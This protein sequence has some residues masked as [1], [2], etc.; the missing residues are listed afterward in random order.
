MSAVGGNLPMAAAQLNWFAAPRHHGVEKALRAAAGEVVVTK[1]LAPPTVDVV[2]ELQ[3]AGKRLTC[4]AA[5]R[6]RI[7]LEQHPHLR[8]QQLAGTE[9]RACLR[10]ML[11]RRVELG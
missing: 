3:I 4:R 11:W 9:D 8:A 2:L 1:P 7:G 10:C 5:R 6:C